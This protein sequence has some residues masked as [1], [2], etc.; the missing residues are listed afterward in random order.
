MI[1]FLIEPD[2]PAEI[3]FKMYPGRVF[4]A[5]VQYVVPASTTGQT[6][7]SGFAPAP[8][9]LPHTPF[10]ILTTTR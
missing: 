8:R 6:P 5:E 4:D 2:Q 3:A 10:L 1:V 9:E 7:L